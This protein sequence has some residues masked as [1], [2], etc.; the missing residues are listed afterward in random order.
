VAFLK[1]HH[2]PFKE[3][4]GID[5]LDWRTESVENEI[6]FQ[7]LDFSQPGTKSKAQY[8]TLTT[9]AVLH[10]VGNTNDQISLFLGNLKSAMNPKGRLIVEEDVILPFD[11]IQN[12]AKY[13]FATD[14]KSGESKKREIFHL[15]FR[16]KL[17][18]YFNLI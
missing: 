11:E 5:V 1:H 15:P 3:A 16:I 8:D 14:K 2:K 18:L 7:M 10:H 4:A 9:I 6:N 13:K 12:N 17:N